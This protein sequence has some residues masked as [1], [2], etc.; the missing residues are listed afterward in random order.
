VINLFIACHDLDLASFCYYFD[1]THLAKLIKYPLRLECQ[2]AVR[3]KL[4]I[5]QARLISIFEGLI[6]KR[7]RNTPYL[8]LIRVGARFRHLLYI[9]AK[10]QN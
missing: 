8:T 2:L 1:L 3:F 5:Q 6:M 4:L 10:R 9:L 7:H